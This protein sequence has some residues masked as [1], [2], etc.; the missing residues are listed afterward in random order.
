MSLT[1]A[2]IYPVPDAPAYHNLTGMAVN[3]AHY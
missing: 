1:S 3:S 2:K